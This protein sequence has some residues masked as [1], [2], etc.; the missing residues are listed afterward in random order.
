MKYDDR[1]WKQPSWKIFL[2]LDGVVVD[3]NG[4]LKEWQSKHPA[5][6][7][8]DTLPYEYWNSLQMFDWALMMHADLQ[9]YAPVVFLTS[10]TNFGQCAAGKL[11]WIQRN[12]KTRDFLI[13]GCKWACASPSSIL[14][15]DNQKK[16]DRFRSA[17]GHGILFKSSPTGVEEMF[18]SL[19]EVLG[20]HIRKRVR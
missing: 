2:D 5:D 4:H 6:V 18:E 7:N 3:F 11:D 19:E 17:G 8:I 14:I 9:K 13:G 15:D 10:P 20:V 12:F 16:I 1:I